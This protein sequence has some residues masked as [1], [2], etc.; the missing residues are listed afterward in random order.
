VLLAADFAQRLQTYVISLFNFL[1]AQKF[2]SVGGFVST[3]NWRSMAASR[4]KRTVGGCNGKAS[5]VSTWPAMIRTG[6]LAQVPRS[7]EHPSPAKPA[8]P[9]LENS[10][11]PKQTRTVQDF[12]SKP[13]SPAANP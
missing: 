7:P 11:D 10:Q 6:D 5:D 2:C 9:E 12:F 3:K 1:L 13:I 8:R 4:K